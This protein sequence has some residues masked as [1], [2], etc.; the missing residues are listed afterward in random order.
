MIKKQNAARS[1]GL[2]KLLVNSSFD[3]PQEECL[4]Y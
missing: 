4:N 2:E 3:L 1:N